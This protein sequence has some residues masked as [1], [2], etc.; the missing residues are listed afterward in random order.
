MLW[1]IAGLSTA[2]AVVA[3]E[4]LRES[5]VEMQVVGMSAS[6]A[7]LFLVVLLPI[8]IAIIHRFTGVSVRR[9]LRDVPGPAFSGLAAVA[10]VF[11]LQESGVI[12]GLSPFPALVVAGSVAL[13]TTGVLLV[14]LDGTARRYARRL[15]GRVWPSLAP[16][17]GGS[18][19]R[20]QR[21]R[22]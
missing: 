6:R 8:N 15:A 4:A 12:D 22:E 2:V 1:M 3:G 5:A 9:F 20:H 7:V 11:A 10:V 21:R 19:E 17:P 18:F 13:L 16:E 14:L